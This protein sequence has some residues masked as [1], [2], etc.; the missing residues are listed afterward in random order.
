MSSFLAEHGARQW[1]I[2]LTCKGLT[3]ALAAKEAA[4]AVSEAVNDEEAP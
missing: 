3:Q 4:E 1:Q 2:N